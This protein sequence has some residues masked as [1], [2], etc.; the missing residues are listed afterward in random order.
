MSLTNTLEGAL[1]MTIYTVLKGEHNEVSLLFKTLK[2]TPNAL[3]SGRETLFHKLR[4]ELLS[5]AHAEQAA[6]YDRVKAKDQNKEFV[7]DA[8]REHKEMEE[9]LLRLGSSAI[10]TDEWMNALK[11]LEEKVRHHVQEEESVFFERMKDLFSS[12]EAEE[13][14]KQF[15][16][17]KNKEIES[18]D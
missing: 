11:H 10:D 3:D 9:L 18:M 17:L 14:A 1:D 2:A 15:R 8:E 7:S 16:D 13:M 6:V 5:H 12:D 4:K